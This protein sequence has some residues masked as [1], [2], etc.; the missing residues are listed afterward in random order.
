M[1]IMSQSQST[2]TYDV[3][4]VGFGAAGAAA[5]IEAA[6]NG[7]KV[8]VLD[9]A[10]GGGASALSGGVIYAGGG[11]EQQKAAGYQDTVDNLYA[12]LKKEVDDAVDDATLR[13]FCEQSPGIIPR[14]EERRVGKEWGPQLSRQNS[15]IRRTAT[16]GTTVNEH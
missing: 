8:L 15:E 9:R 12:Y 13:D 2:E 14:S 7:A 11:T 3:I 6:D 10:Y 16:T 4:I 1:P 5:A